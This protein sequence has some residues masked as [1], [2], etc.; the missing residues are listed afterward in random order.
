MGFIENLVARRQEE[1]K[2]RSETCDSMIREIDAALQELTV[3]FSDTGRFINPAEEAVWKKRHDLLIACTSD[4]RMKGLRKAPH[5][6]ML[7]ERLVTFSHRA[8]TL[9]EQIRV[10]NKRAA[11]L[12][13]Q[14]AYGYIGNV[15]GR[16]L[17]RQQ[18]V[19]II[20]NAP[21]QLVLAG[22]GTGK[23]TTIIGKIQYLLKSGAYK[24]EDILVLSFTNASVKEM[25][26]R[27]YRET[28]H[29]MDVFTFHKLGLHIMTEVDGIRPQVMGLRLR[30]FIKEQ[31]TLEMQD[32]DY[33][34]LLSLYLLDSHVMP[35][36]EFEFS[37]D[38]EYKEYLKHNPPTTLNGETVKSYGEME[39]ANFLAQNGIRYIYEAPYETDTRTE[40]HG[41]Y[42][43]D[44]YLPDHG[45]YI[46]YFGINKNGNVPAYFRGCSGMTPSEAYR[47][48]ME[49]K[50]RLHAANNTVMIECYA[51]E[52][53]DGVLLENLKDKLE[54][55]AVRLRPRP[56]RD[57]WEQ[58][59][60]DGET[61]LS[62]VI[63]L[64]ETLISL[65]KSSG[66]T[67][68]EIREL[69]AGSS[70]ARSN[71]MLLSLL[72][73]IYAAYTEYLD[74]HREI[75]FNDMINT[76]TRYVRLQKFVSPYRYII[77]DEYQD[78][79][80]ARFSLLKSLRDARDCGLFC[81]GDDWQS[82]YRFSG[83]DIG[84]TTHFEKYWGPSAVSRIGTTYRFTQTLTEISSGF[85]MR[86]PA[87]IRK[88]IQGRPDEPGFPLGEISGYTDQYAITFMTKRL[89]DL[90]HGSTV[91][92]I[93]RYSFDVKLLGY[94]DALSCRY[95]TAKGCTCV[96]YA[97]RPDLKM[98]FLTAHKAKGLQAD[99][100]FILNNKNARMGFP[101]KIQ[102]VPILDLLLDSHEPYPY[103][104][105][106][107]LFYVALTRARKKTFIVTV[108]GHESEFVMELK[109][110]YGEELK[111]EPFQCPLC[112]GSLIKRTGPYG[113]FFGCSNY[114]SA[115]C[116]YMRRIN[117]G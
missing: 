69:N 3:L 94:S 23:T 73:P 25:E 76:A 82:I 90:P 78:I 50:R 26:E 33:L 93:G 92:F 60:D 4:S 20:Q 45:I 36:S 15:E 109:E 34:R 77:V 13:I 64:F 7:L 37:T 61:A 95:D 21:T 56:A 89:I 52:K 85:I 39:I 51:H 46:E 59:A 68:E 107:R 19:C 87:Q 86:N 2:R 10:H 88:S 75:D 42:M 31:L 40:Q 49:W 1:N 44:F 43:P 16:R 80:K 14:A 48:G 65:I 55:H 91:F 110:R 54:E 29:H 63:E 97:P 115:G 58:A 101:N 112:G 74:E 105:E 32:S 67:I 28:G 70:N 114:R 103:G 22:A 102:E 18:M 79:S 17:D 47:A 96:T 106:R 8:A 117:K 9:G 108:N 53:L 100:V 72:T 35:R 81:V 27:L 24:P 66:R 62:G 83:S 99:Y 104:E 71:R 5:Y 57:L 41:Q 6:K 38:A 111:R 11:D 12:K 113:A 98:H 116:R 30:T 84:Y